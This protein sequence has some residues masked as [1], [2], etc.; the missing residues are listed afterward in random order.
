MGELPER[1][2]KNIKTASDKH[3]YYFSY[4]LVRLHWLK[5]WHNIH[6]HAT[7]LFICFGFHTVHHQHVMIFA[8]WQS[9][10]PECDRDAL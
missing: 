3:S 10:C 5:E 6:Y 7:Y 9:A 8:S 4:T 1:K 2:A